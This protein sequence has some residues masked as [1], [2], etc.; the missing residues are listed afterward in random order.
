VPPQKN[1]SGV[2]ATTLLPPSPCQLSARIPASPRGDS[3]R[4]D[5]DSFPRA[6]R[7]GVR[8]RAGWGVRVR[9]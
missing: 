4:C 8:D 6:G 5:G 2:P 7:V 9:V 1:T 3:Q